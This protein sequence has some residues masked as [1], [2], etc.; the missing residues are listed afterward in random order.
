MSIA[1]E[2][3]EAIRA[4]ADI[5]AVV[6]QHVTLKKRG[7]SFVG[8]CP[9]HT[10]KTPSFSVFPERQSWHCFG[11]GEGGNVFTFLMRVDSL[12]FP[13]AV[14]RLGNLVGIQVER[15]HESAERRSLRQQIFDANQTAAEFFAKQLKGAP[16]ALDVVRR[17]GLSEESVAALGLGYAPPEWDTLSST[18]LRRN[19]PGEV[20]EKA[21][22]S[23]ARE[24]GGYYD[25]YRDR[26]IF[27]IRDVE[28]RVLGFG[29]RAMG[30]VQPKYLNSPET[31]V[32]DKSRTLYGLDRARRAIA[33]AEMA[34][35]VEGYMDAAMA[36]QE[37]V[38]NVVATLGTALGQTHLEV[39][40]RYAPRVVL[41]YDGD[42]AGSAAAERSLPIF[43]SVD[44][45]GHI[46]ILPP[47][48]DPDDFIRER[49]ADAF[50]QMAASALPLV[51]FQIR[52]LMGR[53]DRSTPEGRAALIRA[54]APVLAAVRQ[55]PKREEYVRRLAEEWSIGQPFGM[56]HIADAIWREVRRGPAHPG[57]GTRV[58]VGPARTGG[59]EDPADGDQPVLSPRVTRAEQFVLQGLIN[60]AAT[61][62]QVFEV[63]T[64]E[65][66][67]MPA[68]REL[69]R[70]L[71]L[72]DEG[73]ED[74]LEEIRRA[75]G[76]ESGALEGLAS[77][78]LAEQEK[79]P[80]TAKM[81]MDSLW[82]IKETKLR[83]R[84]SEL[85]LRLARLQLEPGEERT[86][87]E[88]ELR[89]LVKELSDRKAG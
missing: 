35:V 80:V 29:G 14:E 1:E 34:I 61:P 15:S 24:T 87:V 12:T 16:A 46:L 59:R 31:P 17:R 23:R 45:E 37:G 40:R 77:R 78:M 58:T 48:Q 11:C 13:E 20:L 9:F 88:K 79:L 19:V 18:L 6:S 68:H 56:Q 69:A 83:A 67:Q 71:W 50:R 52:R 41:A 47:G 26:L 65:D 49:G 32:F 38:L 22:L 75:G 54:V 21:G 63:L 25:Y 39:L 86:R 84:I 85:Q 4:R 43:E 82:A 64:P 27:P 33:E 51:E 42:A 70:I 5:V 89:E 44:M 62:D 57:P 72:M 2:T 36:Q 28:G 7:R 60:R 3:I 81:V 74:P 66:F 30:D 76:G 53:G 8:L 10:E 55:H 73:A